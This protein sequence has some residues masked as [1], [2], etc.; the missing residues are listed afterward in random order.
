MSA[1]SFLAKVSP[2]E[3]QIIIDAQ[4][5]IRTERNLGLGPQETIELPLVWCQEVIDLYRKGHVTAKSLE[6]VLDWVLR[7][8]DK[9]ISIEAVVQM[10]DLRNMHE[11]GNV[12]EELAKLS[13]YHAQ[14][15]QT[16][17]AEPSRA[18]SEATR[19]V[20][21]ASRGL[22]NPAEI[23]KAVEDFFATPTPEANPCPE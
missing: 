20:M 12:Q 21:A 15:R 14:W 8:P 1:G 4:D 5:K 23:K 13:V 18:I 3:R 2:Q 11:R 6:N 9:V 10:Q 22:C 16:H 19:A 7:Y 17:T